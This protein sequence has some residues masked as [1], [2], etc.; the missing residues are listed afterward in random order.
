MPDL[1]NLSIESIVGLLVLLG[2]VDVAGSIAIA[3]ASGNFSGT[4]VT[5]F[6]VT[7]VA[8]VWFPIF[9]LAL[10]GHGIAALNIPLIPLANGAA[11]AALAAYAVATIAS[12]KASF[13]DKAPPP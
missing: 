8:K 2:A 13:D 3:L 5:E 4:Y 6:L 10:V 12:L 7:H 9:G 11:L 1:S